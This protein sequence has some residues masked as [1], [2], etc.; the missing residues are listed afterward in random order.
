VRDQK[1]NPKSET[2]S[3]YK[4]FALRNTAFGGPQQEASTGQVFQN[5]LNL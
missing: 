2:I 1:R 5:V 3:K 4:I